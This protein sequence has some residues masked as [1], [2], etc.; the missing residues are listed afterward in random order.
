MLLLLSLPPTPTP[1]TANPVCRL[2]LS[3]PPVRRRRHPAPTPAPTP[4]P[5]TA[6]PPTP[7]ELPTLPPTPHHSCRRP[8]RSPFAPRLLDTPH[9]SR[10]TD[11]PTRSPTLPNTNHPQPTTRHTTP[12]HPLARPLT[13]HSA[14]P[15][16]PAPSLFAINPTRAP[17]FPPICVETRAGVVG[18]LDH[19]RDDI[20]NSKPVLARVGRF[21]GVNWVCAPPRD[22]SAV[23]HL[24][25]Y[26]WG[27]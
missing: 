17:L 11:H 22:C 2:C 20:S 10:S 25:D 16:P 3:C 9:D 14:P 21:R 27:P 6:P 23:L 15:A 13:I 18:N 19:I 8:R 26:V 4:A 1:A 24:R 5:S 12:T 7:T